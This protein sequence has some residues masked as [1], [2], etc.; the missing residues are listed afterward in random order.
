[1]YMHVC[2]YTYTLMYASFTFFHDVEIARSPQHQVDNK[3]PQNDGMLTLLPHVPEI[4]LT[5]ILI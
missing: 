3:P 4:Y 5:L 1:M 2:I